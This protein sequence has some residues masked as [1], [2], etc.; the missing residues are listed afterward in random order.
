MK[1]GQSTPLFLKKTVKLILATLTVYK[2]RSHI[3]LHTVSRSSLNSNSCIPH[4][5]THARAH[6]HT[7]THTQTHTN[8]TLH[9]TLLV[10]SITSVYCYVVVASERSEGGGVQSSQSSE[11]EEDAEQGEGTV[12]HELIAVAIV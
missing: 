5:H 11:G 6:A 4:T 10:D 3:C 12:N 1:L 2:I 8:S 9:Y 7:H